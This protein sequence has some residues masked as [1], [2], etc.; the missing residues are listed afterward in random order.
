M[1][2]FSTKNILMQNRN[3]LL[4]GLI[5]VVIVFFV[6]RYSYENFNESKRQDVNIRP[7]LCDKN[8]VC[9]TASEFTEQTGLVTADPNIQP[10]S[11]HRTDHSS[12]DR[13][14]NV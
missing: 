14:T 9:M 6:Y 5:A 10:V 2:F 8:G 3:M 11:A 12:Q 7:L 13:H 4:F 1:D